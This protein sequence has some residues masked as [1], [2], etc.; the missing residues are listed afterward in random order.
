MGQSLYIQA[1]NVY[2]LSMITTNKGWNKDLNGH[3]NLNFA[4]FEIVFLQ[5][6]GKK[7]P[8]DI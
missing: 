3:A 8:N 5:K 1:P 6:S 2:D 4:C 7:Q